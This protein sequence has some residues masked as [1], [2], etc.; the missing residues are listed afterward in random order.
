MAP[1]RQFDI[2]YAQIDSMDWARLAAFI[3]GEG[4]ICSQLQTMSKGKC[5]TEKLIVQVANTDIRIPAWCQRRFGG[6][7]NRFR[8][9]NPEAGK[10]YAVWSVAS[11]MAEEIIR[12]CM[13]YFIAK[14]EQ[15]KVALLFRATFSKPGYSTTIE[16]K[17]QRSLLA[18][19]LSRLKHELPEE[20]RVILQ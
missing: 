2:D 13:P 6:A 20:G 11:L 16:Q 10:P 7:L 3:D 14:G 17:E 18:K 5:R 8:A 15:A 9:S 12:G 4:T 1:R 19:E